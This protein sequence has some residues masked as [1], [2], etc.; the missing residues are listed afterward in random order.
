MESMTVST[1]RFTQ[2]IAASHRELSDARPA[3]VDWLRD[4]DVRIGDTLADD[5]VVIVTELAANVI[6]HTS[7]PWVRVDVSTD[8]DRVTVE[9]THVG[10][11]ESIPPV[12]AW[13][14]DVEGRRGRGLR[15][16]RALAD[17]VEVLGDDE[18]AAV[19]CALPVS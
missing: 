14:R 9:V 8:A 16:V 10:P 7:S 4:G 3:L 5:I 11:A 6:D 2:Q 15:M 12:H 13:G 18:R 1:A 17:T 19:R